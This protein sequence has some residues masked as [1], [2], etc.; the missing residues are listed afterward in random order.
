MPAKKFCVMTVGRSGSTAL[1]NYLQKFDDIALPCRDIACVDNELLHPSFVAQYQADYAALL[2]TA[3]DSGD[4]LTDAFF[5]MHKKSKYVGFKSMPNRHS[6][7]VQFL[8]K[9]DVQ[10]IA[11]W[12][13]DVASTVASF[14]KAQDTG[15]WRRDGASEADEKWRFDA[16]KHQ[17]AALKNLAYVLNCNAL[18]KNAPNAIKLSYEQLCD[19]DISHAALDQFFKRSIKIDKPKP[20]TSGEQYVENWAEFKQFIAEATQKLIEASQQQ[21]VAQQQAKAVATSSNQPQNVA[22]NTAKNTGKNEVQEL[23]TL[24]PELANVLNYLENLSAVAQQRKADFK[25]VQHVCL[26]IGY[27]RS[28]HSIVGALLDAHPEICIAQELDITRCI[29]AGMRR[30]VIYHLITENSRIFTEQ[31]KKWN[32]YNYQVPGQ[33]QGKTQT[34]KVIGDK[35]GGGLSRAIAQDPAMLDKI[36]ASF[37]VPVKFIH[38]TRNP[39]DNV[40]TLAVKQKLSLDEAA[41]LYFSMAGTAAQLKAKLNDNEMCEISHEDFI[42]KPAAILSQLVEFL[43]LTA[44]PEYLQACAAIVSKKPHQSRQEAVWTDAQKVRMTKSVQQFTFLKHYT[45]EG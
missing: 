41:V 32:T 22:Q 1:M 2:G 31:G 25:A 15:S 21:A 37:D 23:S 6:N 26:F 36:R 17:E 38:I 34:L 19:A 16:K 44:T 43:G 30:N 20:P 4:A 42:A 45:F 12:R 14:M 3:I 9:P 24:M 11:L 33:W 8:S 29:R 35:K 28:G 7:I 13:D 5:N 18:L 10:I 40:A 39:F 27:P